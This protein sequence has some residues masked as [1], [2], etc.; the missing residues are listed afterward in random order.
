MK[1][2]NVISGVASTLFVASLLTFGLST[3][4]TSAHEDPKKPC[5]GH[6]QGDEG[7]EGGSGDGDSAVYTA[8]L[9]MGGFI[10][11]PMV[12]TPKKRGDIYHSDNSL[13][14]SQPNSDPQDLAAWNSVFLA[15]IG[16]LFLGDISGVF[17]DNWNIH[18]STDIRIRFKNVSVVELP[19]VRIDFDLFGELGSDPFLP[20]SGDTSVFALNTY[21]IFGDEKRGP[22][23][24]SSGN[25]LLFPNSILTIKRTK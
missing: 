16:Q 19:R 14:M 7:C 18:G 12:V 11:G 3:S 17:V 23:C 2:W 4:I 9:T 24:R 20:A 13:S 21:E 5:T 6:H 10:F 1:R 22:S 25:P 8:E 15:C